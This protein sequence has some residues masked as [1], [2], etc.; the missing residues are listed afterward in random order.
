[1]NFTKLSGGDYVLR[2]KKKYQDSSSHDELVVHIHIQKAFWEYG[3]FYVS[4]VLLLI[5]LIYIIYN[6]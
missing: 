6:S 4:L 5:G 3:F 2:I 1:V